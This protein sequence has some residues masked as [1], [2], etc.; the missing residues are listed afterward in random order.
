MLSDETHMAAIVFPVLLALIGAGVGTLLN[1]LAEALHHERPDSPAIPRRE[2]WLAA[3]TAVLFGLNGALFGMTLHSASN[4]IYIAVLVVLMA[5]DL[6]HRLIPNRIILPAILFAL[7]VGV[8]MDLMIHP[9]AWMTW[10]A[11]LL[12]GAVGLVFFAVAYGLAAAIYPGKIGLGMGDVTLATFI[13][14]AVGFPSAVVAV[15][16]GVLLGGL[17]SVLLLLTRRVTMRTAIPYGP[18]LILGGLVAMFWG[19]AIIK[20]YLRM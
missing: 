9:M 12:G 14:L 8:L 16:L 13:G 3:V 18:F 1:L 19:A 6:E 15:V 10:K 4:C 5:T 11:A 20:W 2:I 7:A 17:V